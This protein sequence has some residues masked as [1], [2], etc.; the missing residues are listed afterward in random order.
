MY[1]QPRKPLTGQLP[2]GRR[3]LLFGGMALGL[4]A[5]GGEKLAGDRIAQTIQTDIITHGGTSLKAVT[6]PPSIS[7]QKDAKFECTGEL[8]N[9]Y[10][11]TIGVTQRDA[12]GHVVWDVPNTPGLLNMP[13][14]ATLIQESLKSELGDRPIVKCPGTYRPVQP[15]QSFDCA[16]QLSGDPKTAG[17]KPNSAPEKIVVLMD[18]QGNIGWQR[19][20]QTADQPKPGTTPAKDT[21]AIAQDAT[22]HSN[23]T[24]ATPA[25]STNAP[26][27]KLPATS[28]SPTQPAS[29]GTTLGTTSVAQPPPQPVNRPVGKA[30]PAGTD[31]SGGSSEP[32]YQDTLKWQD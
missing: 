12:Q 17:T 19:T 9:G 16:L 15:G 28:Q 13:K 21:P 1:C 14:I 32:T 23:S 22:T 11:F 20:F 27:P 5:C 24:T 10:T 7:P 4:V 8:T 26:N 6:C 18:D 3:L 25:S 30:V 2:R 31:K 29:S